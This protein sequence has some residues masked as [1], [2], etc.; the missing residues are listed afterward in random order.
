MAPTRYPAYPDYR[1]SDVEWLG[2]IPSHWEM[3]R[4]K[5]VAHLEM[6]QSPS[7]DDY[8]QD[9]E[10][11]PFLQ[12]NAE[13]SYKFPI[14]K[15]Y[16]PTA[17]KYA[18]VGDILLSVRAPV[19]AINIA[20]QI[21]GIGRGLCAIQVKQRSLVRDYAWYL[22]PVVKTEL[23]IE[24]TGST[25]DAVSTDNVANLCWNL[26][27][28]DEQRAIADFL[29]RE[30]ARIDALIDAK[31]RLVTL[32]EEKRAALISHAVTRGLDPDAPMKESGIEWLGEIP[33]H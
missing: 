15:H 13:F 3:T 20:D 31:R 25:Y 6:G 22:L 33:S 19:G 23:D 5:F 1:P 14:P 4:L 26:P 16:C 18:G 21:Y 7:S 28:P 8:N 24:S 2:E 32:L 10:G 9:G 29:D 17:N 11:M 27:P 30:T 12:G